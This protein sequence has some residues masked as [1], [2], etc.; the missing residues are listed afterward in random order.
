MLRPLKYWLF[1]LLLPVLLEAC[2]SSA[3]DDRAVF[4]YNETT[5]IASLDPAFAKNQSIMWAVHQ[6]YNTLVEV[7]SNLNIVPS[8]A[9]RLT[10]SPDRKTYTFYLRPDVFFHDDAAFAKGKGRRMT[11]RDVVYSFQRLIAPKT[12]SPGSW[13]FNG[14]VDSVN[15]FKALD[16]TTFQIKLL[17]PYQPILGI[18]SMQYCSIVPREAVEK[19]GSDFRRHAVGTGPFQ[20]VVW[21]EGQALVLKKNPYYF[22][23]AEINCHIWKA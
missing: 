8:L 20:Q 9:T 11:A 6:L 10:I 19:W 13:I 5:G 3:K 7:D 22:E 4:R 15:A 16:D 21:E 23:R 12:A 2:Y 14:K 17:R 18:L 1:L